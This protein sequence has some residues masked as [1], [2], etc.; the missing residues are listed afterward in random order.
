M[1]DHVPVSSQ[2]TLTG[3]IARDAMMARIQARRHGTA[4]LPDLLIL[5]DEFLPELEARVAA[6][7]DRF[8]D[9]CGFHGEL[10]A[11][12]VRLR[13]LCDQARVIQ[14]GAHALDGD[15]VAPPTRMP[16]RMLCLGIWLGL[17][18]LIEAIDLAEASADAHDAR[19]AADVA[20]DAHP[21]I[22]PRQ[23]PE[24]LPVDERRVR[25]VDAHALMRYVA[26]AF[27]LPDLFISGA[28]NDS[29]VW[30]PNVTADDL[31]KKN[32]PAHEAARTRLRRI[33]HR[34]VDWREW[35]NAVHGG[36]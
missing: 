30:L 31:D 28:R 26:A 14:R 23:P 25:V 17:T 2:A 16:T 11:H 15:A 36:A 9:G 1:T 8:Y 18:R 20:L 24:P 22:V 19:R 27:G 3:R 7:K 34:T 32:T 13:R 10:E 21:D 12:P 29:S 35:G 4:E 33:V 5:C 6:L